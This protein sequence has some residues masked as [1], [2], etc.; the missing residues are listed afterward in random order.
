MFSSSGRRKRAGILIGKGGPEGFFGA[1]T[2]ATGFLVLAEGR[3]A[4]FFFA[5]LGALRERAFAFFFALDFLA[6]KF[7]S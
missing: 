5:A 6:M 3:A 7:L 4:A 1:T 2:L